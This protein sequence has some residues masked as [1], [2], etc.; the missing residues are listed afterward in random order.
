MKLT[1]EELARL[2][3]LEDEQA[4][5]AS[6]KWDTPKA[7]R[8]VVVRDVEEVTFTDASSGEDT[9]K[10][11]CTVRTE[12]G[13]EAIWEGPDQLNSKLFKGERFKDDPSPSGPPR[14]GDLLI[15]HYKSEKTSQTSGREWK[16]FDVYRSTPEGP[17]PDGAQV[18]VFA[19]GDDIP[20]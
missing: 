20:Y 3:Q 10:E 14:K 11:V 5:G 19:G 2:E 17:S 4:R 7:V 13:L 15:V 8:G 16:A 18:S 1:Q 12:N 6:V 9:T